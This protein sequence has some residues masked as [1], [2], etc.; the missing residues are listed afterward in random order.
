MTKKKKPDHYWN[1][2]VI[3]RLFENGERGFSVVEVHYD[4]GK[5]TGYGD[6]SLLQDFLSKKELKWTHRKI[7]KAFKKPILDADNHLDKWKP[8][9][10]V[11]NNGDVAE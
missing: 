10:D 4:N 3:T 1:H 11:V 7:K 5:P 9:K 6:K 8:N 2:R